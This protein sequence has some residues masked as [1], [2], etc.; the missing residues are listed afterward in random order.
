MISLLNTI[1]TVLMILG[2]LI[3]VIGVTDVYRFFNK[4]RRCISL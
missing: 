1:A 3:N 4:I 2:L